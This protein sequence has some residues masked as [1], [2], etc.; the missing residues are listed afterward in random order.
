MGATHLGKISA[1]KLYDLVRQLDATFRKKSGDAALAEL[2]HA[3][4]FADLVLLVVNLARD[5]REEILRVTFPMDGRN[6]DLINRLDEAVREIVNALSTRGAGGTTGPL[7]KDAVIERLLSIAEQLENA[8]ISSHT[9]ATRQDMIRETEALIT[10][11]KDWE[12]EDYAKRTL[13]M[14]LNYVARVIQAADSYSEGE[15]RLRVKAIIA[16]FASEFATMD[17]KHQTQ[18]ERLAMWGR[19]GFFAGTVLLG[20]SAD[21]TTITAALP[22]PHLMLGKF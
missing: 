16:D 15:L 22:P 7:V 9:T 11:V 17:K 2:E 13:M 8:G 1:R 4:D 20:L 14:Q 5:T 19:R 10:E 21:V 12:L 6:S 3:R 18:L